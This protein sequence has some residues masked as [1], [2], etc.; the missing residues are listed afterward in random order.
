MWKS[1]RAA[2]QAP[3]AGRRKFTCGKWLLSRGGSRDAGSGNTIK[4]RC[5]FFSESEPL[6]RRSCL[7]DYQRRRLWNRCV[8]DV[9]DLAMIC[10]VGLIVP[11]GDRV[12]R[13]QGHRED[14]RHCQ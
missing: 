9:A 6:G 8:S 3:R 14:D 10:V 11:V 1:A 12:G 2:R 13:E 5:W 4:A 7:L